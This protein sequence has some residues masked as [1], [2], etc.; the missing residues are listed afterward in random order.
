MST[1]HRPTGRLLVFLAGLVLYL[2]GVLFLWA[3]LGPQPRYTLPAGSYLIRVS[4]DGRFLVTVQGRWNRT[5]SAGFIMLSGPVQLRDLRTGA[6]LLSVLPVA[7]QIKRVELSPDGRRLAVREDRPGQGSHVR[8]FDCLSGKE[9][10]A[11]PVPAAELTAWIY[12]RFTPDS[13]TLAIHTGKSPREQVRLW[14]VTGARPP[15][16]FDEAAPPFAFA[17]DGK[18]LAACVPDPTTAAPPRNTGEIRLFDVETGERRA[19]LQPRRGT[20]STVHPWSAFGFSA[21]GTALVASYELADRTQCV[22]AWDVQAQREAA[23]LDNASHA[24]LLT[25]GTTVGLYQFKA[26]YG[27]Q[28][29]VL[30]DLTGAAAPTTVRAR[31]APHAWSDIACN[32]HPPCFAGTDRPALGFVAQV[33][34]HVFGFRHAVQSTTEVCEATTGA[35]IATYRTA[36]FS[37]PVLTPDRGTVLISSSA[38]ESAGGVLEAWDVPPA[39]PTVGYRAVA[40]GGLTALLALGVWFLRR[41][42]RRVAAGTASPS[43]QTS[44]VLKTSEV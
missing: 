28:D 29:Y 24:H 40:V 4:D 16:V 15:R 12:F 42:G 21:D 25:D 1:T 39:E 41:R 9:Q 3:R 30:L 2:G 13:R 17:P 27:S 22:G 14:D 35:V 6:E 32:I 38:D 36:G 8:V 31:L 34:T 43:A 10:A 23:W 11:L 7:A 44:E 26:Y 37:F 20:V 18:L 33:L 19:S 5:G